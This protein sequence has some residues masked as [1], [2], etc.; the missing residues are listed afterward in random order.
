VMENPA[1]CP[2]CLAFWDFGTNWLGQV[3]EMH[4][5]T[6]CVPPVYAPDIPE[7]WEH[8]YPTRECVECTKTFKLKKHSPSQ[9]VCGARCR[10]IREA[11]AKKAS[12]AE[13]EAWWT[14]HNRIRAEKKAQVF[15]RWHRGRAA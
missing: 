2:K 13:R 9:I 6:P 8:E 7:L 10:G 5:V 4:P 15:A 12:D 1:K 3:I 14:E 11:N